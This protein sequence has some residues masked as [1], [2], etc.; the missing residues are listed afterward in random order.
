MKKEDLTN[1]VESL[2][3]KLLSYSQAMVK[4]VDLSEQLLADAISVYFI[5][6]NEELANFSLDESKMRHVIKKEIFS[7]LVFE[8]H[9]LSAQRFKNRRN[10]LNDKSDDFSIFNLLMPIEKSILYL[11]YVQNLSNGEIQNIFDLESHH[12]IEILSNT[13]QKFLRTYDNSFLDSFTIDPAASMVGA[14]VNGNLKIEDKEAVELMLAEDDNLYKFYLSKLDQR[15]FLLQQIPAFTPEDRSLLYVMEELKS[16][17]EESFPN[18]KLG[19]IK[20]VAS[21]LDTPFL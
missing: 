11:K 6:E 4:D 2:L 5:R 7:G 16:S 21:F 14:L 18:D 8:I 3:P 12:C 13:S 1:L 9:R 17:V 15:D 19:L 20:K 10:V